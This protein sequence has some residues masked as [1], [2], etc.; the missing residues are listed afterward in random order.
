MSLSVWV[1]IYSLIAF[2]YDGVLCYSRKI[3]LYILSIYTIAGYVKRE[4]LS[5]FR[6]VC[7]ILKNVIL[8]ICLI[9]WQS[10]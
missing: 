6:R 10:M 8:Q 4:F 7:A 1:L 3:L 2:W 5:L 9:I